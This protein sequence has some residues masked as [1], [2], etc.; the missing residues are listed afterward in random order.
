MGI[1]AGRAAL[2]AFAGT[3]LLLPAHAIAA[4]GGIIPFGSQDPSVILQ[5]SLTSADAVRSVPGASLLGS[6]AFDSVRGMKPGVRGGASFAGSSFATAT[7]AGQISLEVE[8]VLIAQPSPDFA[9]GVGGSQGYDHAQEGWQSLLDVHGSDGAAIA[10]LGLTDTAGIGGNYHGVSF[11][12]L[13]VHSAGKSDFVRLTLSWS[14]GAYTLYVDG[15]PV[16]TGQGAGLAI[17]QLIAGSSQPGYQSVQNHYIR[18]L[19]V[20]SQ[21]VKFPVDPRLSTVVIYGDSFATQANPTVMGSTNFESTAGFQLRRVMNNMGLSIGSVVLR[22]YPGETLNR[23]PVAGQVSFQQGPSRFDGS[24]DKLTDVV[25]QNADYVVI[26]GGTNDAAGDAPARGGLAPNFAADLLSLCRALL[27]NAQTKAVIIQTIMSLKGNQTFAGANY[28]AY[29]DSVNAAI[30]GLPAAWDAAYP[31]EAGKIRVTD[32]FTATGGASPPANMEKGTL[33]G[34][35]DDLHPT[36]FADVISGNLIAAALGDLLA[37]HG[38]V[39]LS[40]CQDSPN[41]VLVAADAVLSVVLAGTVPCT[42]YGRLSTEQFLRLD[43]AGLSVSLGGGFQPAAEQTF[44]ILGWSVLQGTFGSVSLPAL[45]GGLA[46]DSSLLYT[47]GV[48]R[49]A[50]PAAPTITVVSGAAQTIVAGSPATPVGFSLSGGGSLHVIA[51]SSN[52]AVLANSGVT[53]GAGCGTTALSCSAVLAPVAGAV[54]SATVTLRVDDGYGQSSSATATL[55]VSAPPA[56]PSRSGGGGGVDAG[57][58]GA[59]AG[60]CLARR[61]NLTRKASSPLPCAS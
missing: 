23:Q 30:R 43:G 61:F 2:L 36:A 56:P 42:G 33:T 15:V 53:I 24:V 6:P 14:A 13:G 38:S 37:T 58:L 51:T 45:T 59:L 3:C 4:V 29:V 21:P 48:L 39:R 20:A 49:V 28:A 1:Q 35:L 31:S 50:P 55:A 44:Q 26:M 10:S 7:A 25:N 60:L 46:W 52:P 57:F 47:S 54:G 17:G 9:G 22:D 19:V 5:S 8:T 40:A 18:N 41:G 11:V 32:L 34:A 12:G 16:F 27:N